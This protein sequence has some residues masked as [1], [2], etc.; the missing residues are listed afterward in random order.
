MGELT[1]K[2][3][4]HGYTISTDMQNHS[5]KWGDFKIAVPMA[6]VFVVLFVIFNLFD[7]FFI[8]LYH[9]LFFENVLGSPLPLKW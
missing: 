5:A 4:P 2:L 9:I 6:F 3:R 8:L 1:L 7:I